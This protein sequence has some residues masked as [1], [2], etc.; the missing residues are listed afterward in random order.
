MEVPL[1]VEERIESEA[2]VLEDSERIELEFDLNCRFK[3]N[4]CRDYCET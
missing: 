3:A 1:Y 2:D 4:A